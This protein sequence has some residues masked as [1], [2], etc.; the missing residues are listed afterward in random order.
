MIG[1]LI[2]FITLLLCILKK[3]KKYIIPLFI[4]VIIIFSLNYNN[5]D[6]KNYLNLYK[7]SSTEFFNNTGFPGYMVIMRLCNLLGISY[8]SF[9]LIV[10]I[11][12]LGLIL[13]IFLKLSNFPNLCF[14]LYCI[15]PFFSDVIQIRNFIVMV[16]LTLAIVILLSQMKY[17]K[18][19]FIILIILASTVQIMALYYLILIFYDSKKFQCISKNWKKS[20]FFSLFISIVII[21]IIP[22]FPS[23]FPINKIQYFFSDIHFHSRNLLMFL[24]AIVQLLLVNYILDFNLINNKFLLY[25]NYLSTLSLIVYLSTPLI[26]FS[27]QFYRIVRNFLPIYYFI[28]IE[29]LM[30]CNFKKQKK[31]LFIGIQI[32]IAFLYMVLNQFSVVKDIM[33]FNYIFQIFS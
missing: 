12:G 27:F 28:F 21:L 3:E 25:K 11:S 4:T 19:I 1:W 22:Y 32:L 26:L 20:I 2:Y 14:S 17:K 30:S 29:G 6:Y 16:I 18:I 24:A 7:L 10:S 31:L 13:I 8:Q 23:F 15:A 33:E 5:A 9:L